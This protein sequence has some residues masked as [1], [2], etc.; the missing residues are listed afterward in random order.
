[1]G[2]TCILVGTD[3]SATADRAVEAAAELARQL[4]AELHILSVYQGASQPDWSARPALGDPLPPGLSDAGSPGGL[5]ASRQVVERA[6]STWSQGL[7]A[8]AHAV[9]GSAVDA[10][11][12]TA[13]S[14]GADLVVVG[15]KGMRGARRVLGSVPNSVAHRAP[16]AVLIVKT[17]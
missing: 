16:C 11:V 8:H 9:A 17:D 4:G 14:V 7:P 6:L 10:I 5:L 12:G 15:S 1:M 2:F 13:A 3:G